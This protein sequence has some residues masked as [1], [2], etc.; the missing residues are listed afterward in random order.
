M[1]QG[2]LR[3]EIINDHWF[4]QLERQRKPYLRWELAPLAWPTILQSDWSIVAA[5]KINTYKNPIEGQPKN[6]N[7]AP[8]AL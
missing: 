6:S 8:S 1:R 7:L 4:W 5:Y 3:Q 2:S